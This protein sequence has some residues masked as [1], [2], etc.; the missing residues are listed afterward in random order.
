[1]YLQILVSMT[2][3]TLVSGMDLQC[4]NDYDETMDCHFSSLKSN[5]SE[6]NLELKTSDPND[7]YSCIFKEIM[8]SSDVICSCSISMR[9]LIISEEF[10]ATLRNQSFRIRV[11]N[12]I[13]PK[14]PKITEVKQSPNGNF[15]VTWTTNH[16]KTLADKLTTELTYKKTGDIDGVSQNTSSTFFEILGTDLEPN[17]KYV[18]IIRTYT[19]FSE[20]FSDSSEEWHFTT[21]VG[22]SHVFKIVIV[23]LSIVAISLTCFL[24]WCFIRLKS[25]CWDTVPKY[26]CPA[27]LK[28]DSKEPWILSP[29][30][31]PLCPISVDSLKMNGTEGKQLAIQD[32]SGQRHEY[33]SEAVHDFSSQS[34]A[35]TCPPPMNDLTPCNGQK[36]I[37]K[38][39]AELFK[40]LHN[41]SMSQCYLNV[42]NSKPINNLESVMESPT[43][44]TMGHAIPCDGSYNSNEIKVTFPQI[45]L[46]TNQDPTLSPFEEDSSYHPCTN[47]FV[48][49]S[50]VEDIS[51]TCKTKEHNTPTPTCSLLPSGDDYQALQSLQQHNS[52]QWTLSHS[53]EQDR[54]CPES[55]HL[56]SSETM[57]LKL[58]C[59]SQE[60]LFFSMSTFPNKMEQIDDYHCV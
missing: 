30:K 14:R 39:Q 24:F 27:L 31:T 1:M 6:Y 32:G 38:T 8:R 51:L 11:S 42:P 22:S 21:P 41:L 52:C 5:C 33:E 20:R 49:S 4:Y 46:G 23:A 50:P 29:S 57:P 44:L 18:L 3:A 35:L 47:G 55:K 26:P 43:W 48:S 36:Q 54:L 45:F 16:K 17:T 25:K 53:A 10:T 60:G 28:I 13:K 2:C 59:N 15:W 7:S 56:Q 37:A 19:D 9:S 34:Y 40:V 12:S 58:M